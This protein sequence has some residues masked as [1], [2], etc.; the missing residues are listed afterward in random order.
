MHYIGIFRLPIGYEIPE[1]CEYSSNQ[2]VDSPTNM[3]D[4]M[5]MLI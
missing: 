2:S 3:I 4:V 5:K 1:K